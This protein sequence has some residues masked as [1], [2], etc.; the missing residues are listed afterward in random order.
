MGSKLSK[1]ITRVKGWEGR[2]Q[3]Q[4]RAFYGLGMKLTRCPG[5]EKLRGLFK[6]KKKTSPNLGR[7]FM[8][9]P[10]PNNTNPACK[11]TGPIWLTDILG[12]HC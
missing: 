1:Y 6:C 4:L 11:L 10:V 7:M 9:C 3:G 2:L 5:C 12:H 8:T